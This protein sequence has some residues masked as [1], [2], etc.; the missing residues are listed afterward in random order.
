VHVKNT[1]PAPALVDRVLAWYLDR[2]PI[3]AALLG[4]LNHDHALGDFSATSLTAQER[5]AGEWLARLVETDVTG[6]DVPARVDRD[7]LIAVLRGMQARASW[8]VWRRDPAHYVAPVLSGLFAAFLHRL[9]PE[10]ELVRAVEARLAE[11][12]AVLDACRAN[13]D[14]D[15]SSPLLVRRALGQVR[16]ARTFLTA[17]LPAEVADDTLRT[18]VAAA[19]EPAAAAFDN[20][21]GY[22]TEFAERASGDWRMGEKLYST[23]LTEQEM[24][25]YDAAELHA[26]GQAAYD[27]LD[28]QMRELAQRVPDGSADW[29]AVMARLQNDHP[30]TLE[31]MRAEY[32]AE[33]ARARAF[34]AEH[35]LVSF[36]EGEECRVVP[37]PTFQRPVLSVA[38]YIAPPPLTAARIGHFF[39][40]YTPDE[41]TAEQVEQRLRTNAR[42]QMPTIAVHEAYPGHH[43]HLSWLA[44]NPRRVRKVFRTP[45]FA[46]GWALYAERLL[47]EQG[48]FAEPAHELAH[49]EARIFRAAR[50]VVDTAL[51]CGDMTIEQAEEFMTT[52]TSLTPGTAVGEVNRYCAWPT[53]APSYLT[54]ALEIERIRDDYLA[55]G[56]GDLRSFH[57]TVAGSGALPLGL[58][59]RV[60]LE[61]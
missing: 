47:R 5:E 26:R 25:G 34:L 3:H 27:E 2:N 50:M 7:L 51:H 41:F 38:F 4:S 49:L 61:G 58:A 16:T 40:P 9:R 48:Y 12:P 60:A 18:R 29:R 39:T 1:T 46:E 10:P 55:A 43:W 22:L 45:Y 13:L 53:Q 30:P 24:L 6:L 59:R 35:E 32:A 36:A 54:G 15:L 28:T 37:S 57:D 14:P 11:V 23:L 31:A 52:H 8:P 17:A 21:A 42:A 33:T 56:R 20:L 19:A 44:G